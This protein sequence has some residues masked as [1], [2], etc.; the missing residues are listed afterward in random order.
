[1]T[2]LIAEVGSVHDGSFGNA[3]KLIDL[4]KECGAD[5]VKFQTHIASEETLATAPQPPFF[6]SE[7]RYDYFERTGFSKSQW[8]FFLDT[9]DSMGIE[10]LSSP[11]SIEALNLLEEIGVKTHKIPSGEVTNLP[12]LE[13]VSK[14]GKPILLSSGMSNWDELD[15]AIKTIRKHNN[16]LTILQC[17]TEYPCKYE[18]VGINVMLEM[19]ERYNI[20]F[21]LSDHTL[22]NYAAFLA[23]SLGATVIEKHLTFSRKMYGSDAKH[24]S[25][26]DEFRELS[27]GIKAIDKMIKSKVDKSE[28]GI[29]LL[30]MKKTF[31]K[32]IVTL[33]DIP[34]GT[35]I[36]EEML[37]IK[38]PGTGVPP[39]MLTSFFGR[40]T[41]ISIKKDS[42]IKLK[43]IK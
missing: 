7:G 22:T 4:A 39:K 34:K 32:S 27:I 20:P 23:V 31:E 13:A 36:T 41:R 40:K 15:C 10:F 11:F 26:P 8:K 29:N 19:K 14:T 25:E 42:L 38:K 9:C 35:K 6:K 12:L 43:D 33:V 24:S 3:L 5:Y 21:G 28:I 16:D 1:M 18:N 37:S 17:T 30:E 2:K